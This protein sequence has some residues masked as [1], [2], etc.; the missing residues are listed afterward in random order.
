[1]V[2]PEEE[3]KMSDGGR[4]MKSKTL[5]LPLTVEPVLVVGFS[6]DG[7]LG[8]LEDPKVRTHEVHRGSREQLPPWRQGKELQLS[9]CV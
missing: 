5:L 2:L 9:V 4:L 1:M 7:R 3:K 8:H 6:P